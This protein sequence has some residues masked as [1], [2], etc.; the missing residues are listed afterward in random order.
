MRTQVPT[1]GILFI[2]FGV[3]S[4]L[5][6]VVMTVL[7]VLGVA[8]GTMDTFAP[9]SSVPA[10]DAEALG[11]GVGTVLGVL[12]Y[13]AWAVAGLF[14]ALAGWQIRQFQWR[15]FAIVTCIAGFI[16][17]FCHHLCC[18]W[19][20][21]LGLGIYGLVVLFDGDVKMAFDEAEEGAGVEE[22]LSAQ[23]PQG[24]DQYP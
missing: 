8:L 19:I 10:S 9:F 1:L 11:Q 21:G 13:F 7:N 23:S 20:F 17:C 3:L 4:F 16:P 18:T 2:V 22:I 12:W 14:Y 24:W 15:T 6:Y 5:F